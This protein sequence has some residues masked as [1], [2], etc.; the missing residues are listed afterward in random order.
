[1]HLSRY[2]LKGQKVYHP[3]NKE[4]H[5]LLPFFHIVNNSTIIPT[6]PCQSRSG[7]CDHTASSSPCS[8]HRCV[9]PGISVPVLSADWTFVPYH[10]ASCSAQDPKP[11]SVC[12]PLAWRKRPHGAAGV[13]RWSARRHAQLSYCPHQPQRHVSVLRSC[14]SHIHAHQ[15]HTH[16]CCLTRGPSWRS[17]H[18]EHSAKPSTD[19]KEFKQLVLCNNC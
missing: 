18:S 2:I 12:L 4:R 10:R 1:M 16:I 5:K 15:S 14:G 3:S 7:R 19:A 6:C 17:R 8:Q 9:Y 11:H 13:V